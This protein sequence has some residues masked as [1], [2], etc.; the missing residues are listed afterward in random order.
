MT[1]KHLITDIDV[2]NKQ[3]GLMI[4]NLEKPPK[5]GD[6]NLVFEGGSLNG[7]YLI[8][9]A[10]FL[11]EL[12]RRGAMRVVKVS[13]TSIGAYIAFHYLNDSLATVYSH[14]LSAKQ[15][16]IERLNLS[17]YKDAVKCDLSG[18]NVASINDRLYVSYYN[19]FPERKRVVQ[20]EFA[21][22]SDLGDALCASAYLPILMDGGMTY[23]M[24]DGCRR[25]IDGGLP[26]LF[27]ES[28]LY[29]KLSGLNKIGNMFNHRGEK[30][31][32]GRV[33]E[34]IVSAYNFFLYGEHG[35]DMCGWV[36]NWGTF[37]RIAHGF[38]HVFCLIVS[39]IV[40]GIVLGWQWFLSNNPGYDA[41]VDGL[42]CNSDLSILITIWQKIADALTDLIIVLVK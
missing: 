19:V 42:L 31:G 20:S 9:V 26:Y 35:S 7:Y 3:I 4:D 33:C 30:N 16:F 18:I 38:K 2:F 22:V 34:G 12:E 17:Y 40:C 27:E 8:G 5:L 36:A 39:F 1:D 10:M 28:T 25:C 41:I 13:G 29:V 11:K 37:D 24:S 14:S 15:S 23:T 21:D 6:I 32:R